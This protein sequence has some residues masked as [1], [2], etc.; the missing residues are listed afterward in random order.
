M[1]NTNNS[2]GTKGP[3]NLTENLNSYIEGNEK[4]KSVLYFADDKDMTTY[5][6]D[7]RNLDLRIINFGLKLYKLSSIAVDIIMYLHLNGGFIKGNYSD[8][9]RA[10][11]RKGGNSGHVSAVRKMCKELEAKG[12]LRVWTEKTTTPIQIDLNSNW[13]ELL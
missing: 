10:L 4:L 3:I 8:L 2:K 7:I 9:T 11:G 1:P 12:I 5:Q 6:Q 13:I